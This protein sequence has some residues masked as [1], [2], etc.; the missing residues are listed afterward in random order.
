M[1]LLA[2]IFYFECYVLISRNKN[3]KH[4]MSFSTRPAKPMTRLLR[5]SSKKPRKT[6]NLVKDIDDTEMEMN[7]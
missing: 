7:V 4:R 5:T 3:L 1:Y 6:G 2:K